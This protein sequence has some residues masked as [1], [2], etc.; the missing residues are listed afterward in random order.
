[1]TD[2]AFTA[3]ADRLLALAEAAADAAD[4]WT[5]VYNAVAAPGATDA[6]F[7]T[8]ELR[9]RFIRSPQYA[10][11]TA[12]A[13]SVRRAGRDGLPGGKVL[14]RMPRS[15]HAALAREADEEG[16][17]MNQLVVSKLSAA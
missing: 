10:R 15:L 12:L 5:D 6:A 14:V 4:D 1:M 11:I 7:P 3:H 17:S 2:D 9:A 8:R 16:V 13:E